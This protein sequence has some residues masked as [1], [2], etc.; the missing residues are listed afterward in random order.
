M[1]TVRRASER[2]HRLKLKLGG[3]DGLDG[4]RVRAGGKVTERPRQGDVNEWGSLDGAVDSCA[5]RGRR[6]VE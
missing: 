4:E 6:G 2:F 1:I 5:E 3:A